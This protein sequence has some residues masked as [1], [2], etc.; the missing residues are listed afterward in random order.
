[1]SYS[2]KEGL[3][4]VFPGI[5]FELNRLHCLLLTTDSHLHESDIVVSINNSGEVNRTTLTTGKLCAIT[6]QKPAQYQRKNPDGEIE[7]V[8]VSRIIGKL[9]TAS[10]IGEAVVEFSN[11]EGD[12]ILETAY[13]EKIQFILTQRDTVEQ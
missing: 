4:Y 1:M 7:K 6:F 2:F 13:R 3:N 9:K 11:Q 12:E 8:F 5:E 10:V